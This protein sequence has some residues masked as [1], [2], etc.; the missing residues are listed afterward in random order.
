MFHKIP[1]RVLAVRDN[2]NHFFFAL[3]SVAYIIMA[4]RIYVI[5]AYIHR[6]LFSNLDFEKHVCFKTFIVLK[7]IKTM[8]REGDK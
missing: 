5:S 2:N 8:H 7:I 1:L 3:T 4:I 6:L